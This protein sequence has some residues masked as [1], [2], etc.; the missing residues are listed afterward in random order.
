MNFE[1]NWQNRLGQVNLGDEIMIKNTAGIFQLTF[2]VK[3]HCFL[4]NTSFEKILQQCQ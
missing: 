2:F 4:G 1:K 3:I